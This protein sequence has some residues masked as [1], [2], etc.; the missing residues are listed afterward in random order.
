MPSIGDRWWQ[1][2]VG[3]GELVR[4]PDGRAWACSDGHVFDMAKEGYINLLV[5][6]QRRSHSPGDSQ[7]MVRRRR[8]FLD[9]G[10]Y[11]RLSTAVSDAMEALLPSRPGSD[12]IRLLDVGCGEGY[13]SAD[14]SSRFGARVAGVDIAKPAVRAAS[15]RHGEPGLREYAVASAFDLPLPDGWAHGLASVFSPI[16]T[17]S[18]DRV[19]GPGGVLV[20]ATPGPRQLWQLKANL[21]AEPEEHPLEPPLPDPDWTVRLQ[22]EIEVEGPGAAGDLLGMTPYVWYVSPE[23]S[24]AV[25]A[26]T[27]LTTEADFIVAGYLRG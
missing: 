2:P 26:M 27:S 11:Q 10:H 13:Y 23:I 7:E 24:G 9:Q 22:Y 1:C 15:K 4:T 12:P 18:F 21:F 14:W 6:H 17:P 8:S 19:L 3:G 16:D 20:T 25:E 5:S